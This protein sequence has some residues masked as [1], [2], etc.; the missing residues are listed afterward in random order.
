M[1]HERFVLPGGLQ[2][3][4]DSLPRD[5]EPAVLTLAEG[6]FRE[7]V[8][9]DRPR[10]T[11]AGAGRDRTRIVWGDGALGQDGCKTPVLNVYGTIANTGDSAISTNGTDRSGAR[12]N[13]FEGAK[14][15]SSDEIAISEYMPGNAS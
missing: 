9:L 10:T 14:V 8:V 13:V 6:V 5:G 11:L 15:T 1:T 12:I 3:A 4:I 7:K 2:A